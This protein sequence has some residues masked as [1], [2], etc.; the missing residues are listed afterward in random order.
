MR[1]TVN[2]RS[3]ICVTGIVVQYPIGIIKCTSMSTDSE[4]VGS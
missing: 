1:Y 3:K 2:S 4:R